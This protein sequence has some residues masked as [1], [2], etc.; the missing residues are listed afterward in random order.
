MLGWLAD[1]GVIKV[2]DGLP[3]FLMVFRD[4]LSHLKHEFLMGKL[5]GLV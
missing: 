2:F 4:G 5:D 1:K 3:K